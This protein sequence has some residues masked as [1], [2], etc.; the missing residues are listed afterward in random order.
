MS[1]YKDRVVPPP[2]KLTHVFLLDTVVAITS[3]PHVMTGSSAPHRRLPPSLPIFM[4]WHV[5]PLLMALLR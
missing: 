3:V 4:R 5:I 2:R 1:D